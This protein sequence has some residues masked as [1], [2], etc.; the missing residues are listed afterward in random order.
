MADLEI[1]RGH[2]ATSMQQLYDAVDHKLSTMEGGIQSRLDFNE[3]N[4]GVQDLFVRLEEITRSA[5]QR[6]QELSHQVLTLGSSAPAQGGASS[7]NVLTSVVTALQ[8]EVDDLQVE[9]LRARSSAEA[10][11]TLSASKADSSGW[12]EVHD[13]VTSVFNDAQET[14]KNLDGLANQV[15]SLKSLSE[16]ALRDVSTLTARVRAL[17]ASGSRRQTP[18]DPARPCAANAPR[19]PVPFAPAAGDSPTSTAH[20]TTPEN[21]LGSVTSMH[22]VPVQRAASAA[23]FDNSGAQTPLGSEAFVAQSITAARTGAPTPP[24]VREA[25]EIKLAALPTAALC[26]DWA[27]SLARKVANATSLTDEA[28][29]WILEVSLEGQTFETSRTAGPLDPLPV[30]YSL[31]WRIKSRVRLLWMLLSSKENFRKQGP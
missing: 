5:D 8:R 26:K 19:P 15:R 1:E 10:A 23:Q 2:N 7:D 11:Q 6:F 22:T 9:M 30:S 27:Y 21:W 12:Q 29:K 28:F 16:Q 25:D 3:R 14:N 24:K 4:S 18:S 20:L 31:R 13:R 17:E